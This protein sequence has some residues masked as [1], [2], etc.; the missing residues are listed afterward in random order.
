MALA[1]RQGCRQLSVQTA[2][3][4]ERNSK[5]W[6]GVEGQARLRQEWATGKLGVLVLAV[7]IDALRQMG[8][9]WAAVVPGRGA[10]LHFSCR[11]KSTRRATLEDPLRRE[12]HPWMAV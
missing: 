10:R 4:S 8:Y 12:S 3:S 1:G 2:V 11:D 5:E 6:R 9:G 7:Q